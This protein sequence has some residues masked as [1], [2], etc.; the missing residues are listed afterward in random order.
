[1]VLMLWSLKCTWYLIA[2]DVLGEVMFYVYLWILLFD[3]Y[4]MILII[5]TNLVTKCLIGWVAL[6][7]I[8]HTPKSVIMDY[9]EREREKKKPQTLGYDG[10]WDSRQNSIILL[11][12]SNT[13][14]RPISYPPFRK[15]PIMVSNTRL[16]F[17]DTF[18]NLHS[19]IC[20]DLHFDKL[21]N[22]IN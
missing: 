12:K 22:P 16:A 8:Y 20:L 3:K 7:L 19:L 18:I 11:N 4:W 13:R 10:I 2:Q 6:I 15:H 1:M 21:T 5:A 17:P 9:L 14:I